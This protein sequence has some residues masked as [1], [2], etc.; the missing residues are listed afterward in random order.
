MIKVSVC[1]PIYNV[2]AYIERCARSLFGQTCREVEYIF[3]DDCSPDNSVE[4]LRRVM[5]EYAERMPEVRIV[6]HE[7]NRGL[8]AARNTAVEQA[9][10]EYIM[11]VD[12]DDYLAHD[13][14]VESM[15]LKA[16][17]TNADIVEA[18]YVAVTC[19]GKLNCKNI[20]NSRSK[21]RLLAD[22]ICKNTQITIWNKLI[23]RR[24]Y[25]DHNISV[26]DRLNNGEDYVTLPD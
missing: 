2:S 9:K 21:D 19:N 8:S 17:E 1:I 4:I 14:V 5:S 24:L 11:H 20:R 25:V 16:E 12:S 6:R 15:I 22:V 7:Q 23:R 3:I 10:G 18:D 13:S 26:P